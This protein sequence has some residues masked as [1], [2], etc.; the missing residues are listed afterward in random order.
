MPKC[1][2]LTKKMFDYWCI[3]YET[4]SFITDGTANN[5]RLAC[6][7]LQRKNTLAFFTAMSAIKKKSFVTIDYKCKC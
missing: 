2:W 5:C 4:F 3:F 1:Q 6:K 7:D